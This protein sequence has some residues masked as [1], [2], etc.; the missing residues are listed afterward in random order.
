MSIKTAN[1]ETLQ[2]LTEGQPVLVDCTPAAQ[3][4]ALAD[5]AYVLE[6]GRIVLE[7]TSVEVR[8]NP[9]VLHAYLGRTENAGR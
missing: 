6:R 4:L 7:G 2:R 9:M 5:R 8:E 3:A 1:R